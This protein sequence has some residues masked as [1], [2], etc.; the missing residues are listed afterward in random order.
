MNSTYET[1][2]VRM[3]DELKHSL[4]MEMP[5]L[6]IQAN[7]GRSILFVYPP[8]DNQAY[9]D[10][11]KE[12][13]G[14]SCEFIDLADLFTQFVD[15]MGYDAFQEAYR[16]IGKEIYVSNNFSE[17]TFYSL[18][19]KR[20][21]EVLSSGKVPVIVHTEAIYDM[22]FTNNNIMEE[23]VVLN[24]KIPIVVFYPATVEGETIKFL[25][26]QNASKYRCIVIK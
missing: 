15:E 10:E 1:Q 3:F 2:H 21:S 12:T 22:G 17:G 18:I 4:K 13:L 7:G 20:I 19:V 14:S 5:Q 25:G 24:S 9:I 23:K 26:K 8:A 11:A 6:A 16:E